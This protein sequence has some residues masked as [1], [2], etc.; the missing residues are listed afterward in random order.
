MFIE[1]EGVGIKPILN[2]WMLSLPQELLEL[3][4]DIEQYCDWLVPE[5]LTFIKP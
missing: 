2:R 1:D 5:A 4:P 3:L